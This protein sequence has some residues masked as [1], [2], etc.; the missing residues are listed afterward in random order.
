MCCLAALT[1]FISA[2]FAA[3]VWWIFD[4]DRW[5]IAFDSFLVGLIGFMLVPWLTLGWVLVSPDGVNG[6]DWVVLALGLIFDLGSYSGG[7]YSRSRR[8]A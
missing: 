1:V 4:R 2:R 6:F 5:S 3:F 7:G 8:Y